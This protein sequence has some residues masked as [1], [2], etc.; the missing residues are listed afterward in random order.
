MP[1]TVSVAITMAVTIVALSV[2]IPW[3]R[4]IILIISMTRDNYTEV[5]FLIQKRFAE[6]T[7]VFDRGSIWE[8]KCAIVS[9][10]F[11]FK[12]CEESCGISVQ[13]FR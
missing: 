3:L 5:V 13:L 8:G 11:G 6:L 12:D 4:G 10:L 2:P 9:G 1:I 7:P